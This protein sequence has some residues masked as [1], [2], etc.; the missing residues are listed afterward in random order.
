M[1]PVLATAYGAGLRVYEVVALKVGDI[2]SERTLYGTG[3]PEI[4]VRNRPPRPRRLG[5]ATAG[6]VLLL[7]QIGGFAGH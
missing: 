6:G 2:D 4:A 3:A 1:L 7:G 5:C